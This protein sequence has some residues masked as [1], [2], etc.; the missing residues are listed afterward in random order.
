MTVG[1]QWAEAAVGGRVESVGLQ[2]VSGVSLKRFRLSD[3]VLQ[4]AWKEPAT[5]EERWQVVVQK[6]LREAVLGACHGCAGFGHFGSSKT[7][8]W[9][10]KG[11]YWGQHRRDVEDFCRRCDDCVAHKGPLDQSHAPLQQQASG[12]PMERVGVD[13]LGPFPSGQRPMLYLTR[14]PKQWQMH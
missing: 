1:P 11:F 8:C 9:L 7:L 5:G 2:K 10:R 14:R 4:R 3:G 13:I 6:S 12:A